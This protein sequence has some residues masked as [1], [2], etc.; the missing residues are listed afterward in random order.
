MRRLHILS[1]TLALILPS[2]VFGAGGGGGGGGGSAPTPP[3]P[4]DADTWTCTDWSTCSDAGVQTRSCQITGDCLSIESPQPQ[5]IQTC[6]PPSGAAPPPPPTSSPPSCIEDTWTCSPWSAC[7]KIGHEVRTCTLTN[8]CRPA[9]TPKPFTDR[10]CTGIKCAHLSTMLE[11]VR[12]R[13]GL[14]PGDLS[15]EFAIQYAPELCRAQTTSE[16][17]T[18]CVN[19]YRALAPCWDK[20]AGAPRISCAKQIIGLPEN[21]QE[22][23]DTCLAYKKRSEEPLR[24]KCLGEFKEKVVWLTIFRMYNLEVAAELLISRGA[25]WEKVAEFDVQVEEH[26]ISLYAAQNNAERIRILKS[27]RT[28]WRLFIQD[29]SWRLQ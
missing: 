4:C 26:K 10:L 16:E 1:I 6:T 23:K 5:E 3:P 22:A 13:L 9:V 11:R 29:I 15:Q 7:N 8:D 18:E 28:A 2:L 25:P 14:S 20:P 21:L 27:L 17:F 12:C 19:L 24:V